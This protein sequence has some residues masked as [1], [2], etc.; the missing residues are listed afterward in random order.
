MKGQP[1]I[2]KKQRPAAITKSPENTDDNYDESEDEDS[3]YDDENNETI[4]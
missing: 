1:I 3:S 2:T 4:F